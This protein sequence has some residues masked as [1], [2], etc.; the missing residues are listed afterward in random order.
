MLNRKGNITVLIL[1]PLL[2]IVSLL[3]G[4]F[5]WQ[6]QQASSNTT[7]ITE[8]TYIIEDQNEPQQELPQSSNKMPAPSSKFDIA[9]V[10]VGDKVG[11][12]T[13]SAIEPFMGDK[14]FSENNAKVTF[15][16]P[17]TVTGDYFQ[18]GPNELFSDRMG[19]CFEKFD[20]DSL[21]ILPQKLGEYGH[22][23]FCFS[24][25]SFVDKYFA[26]GTGQATI[27]I[28]DYEVVNLPA[29]VWNSARL[30]DVIGQ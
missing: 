2:V 3:A 17:I 1:V 15:K 20:E 5:Y 4:F 30:I 14:P 12:M 16:G 13:V 18:M 6:W 25:N 7:A 24:N 8:T 28:D 21:D 19:A 22:P 9:T 29:E 27:I 23:L 26:S 10:K 11:A